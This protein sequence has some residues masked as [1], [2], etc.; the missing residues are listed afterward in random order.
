MN[1]LYLV[2][3]SCSPVRFDPQLGFLAPLEGI[4]GGGNQRT[5]N[6]YMKSRVVFHYNDY[7]ENSPFISTLS[8]NTCA[9]SFSQKRYN[10]S[11]GDVEIVEI[12][13]AALRNHGVIFEHVRSIEQRLDFTVEDMEE[14][15]LNDG[16]PPPKY[17]YRPTRNK[18]LEYLCLLTIPANCEQRRFSVSDF[19]KECG[20][21][22]PEKI[23]SNLIQEFIITLMASTPK[24]PSLK[25]AAAR[26]TDAPNTRRTAS[27]MRGFGMGMG[28]TSRTKMMRSSPRTL[29]I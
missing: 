22:S 23:P 17:R 6:E 13:C 12:N 8:C 24:R 26:L 14:T 21:M 1:R 5:D 15:G 29:T 2:L 28:M 9:L 16:R 25:S 10:C 27:W 11:F 7:T 18:S 19:A 20:I 4:A 3:D